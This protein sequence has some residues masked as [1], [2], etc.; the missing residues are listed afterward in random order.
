[1]LK[2][3]L[4]ILIKVQELDSKIAAF[5]QQKQAIPRMLDSQKEALKNRQ[6]EL[7]AAKKKLEE[8]Q[9]EKKMQEIEFE[10][11]N[12]ELKKLQS[13]L[14]SVKTNK[15][16]SAIQHEVAHIKDQAGMFEEEIIKKMFDED[17]I[18]K[19]IAGIKGEIQKEE[20]RLKD[21]E[22]ECGVEAAK[23][24]Q[25]M[26]AVILEKDA[27]TKQVDAQ[28]LAIYE[29]IRNKV[30]GIG[31]VEIDSGSCSGCF[32]SLRP[33]LLIETKKNENLVFCENCGRILCNFN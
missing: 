22:R 13:Q 19:N 24:D 1:M 10:T 7:E 30:S 15:E 29:N 6:D 33:Q 17:E 8:F 23:I 5:E 18:R 21:I 3:D 14:F 20:N 4:K 26:N 16:Y 2:D 9:K 25:E 27:M 31:I 12:A 11:K 28:T 32:I